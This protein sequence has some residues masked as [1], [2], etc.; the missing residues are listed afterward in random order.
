MT[1]Q[2]PIQIMNLILRDNQRFD[3]FKSRRDFKNMLRAVYNMRIHHG[4][5]IA[6]K[7][8]SANNIDQ[9]IERFSME[10]RQ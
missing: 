9:N 2:I 5:I 6:Y 8:S 10:N 1:I 7:T 3:I 4:M